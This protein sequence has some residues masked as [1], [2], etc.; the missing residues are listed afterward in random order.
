M[1]TNITASQ[2]SV[3]EIE[4]WKGQD[5]F[6]SS[7]KKLGKLKDIYLD[8]DK[9]IP[10]WGLANVGG[11]FSS[12]DLFIPLGEAVRMDD[13]IHIKARK[14]QVDAA[15]EVPTEGYISSE[16]ETKLTDHYNL[17]PVTQEQEDKQTEENM[18]MPIP[19]QD[20]SGKAQPEAVRTLAPGVEVKLQKP[21]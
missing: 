16:H 20:D 4:N 17:N 13:G 7:S 19:E 2:L 10:K 6:D 11:L 8:E 15:P 1:A 21:Q 18:T 3:D 9:T 5:I 14:E 12:K